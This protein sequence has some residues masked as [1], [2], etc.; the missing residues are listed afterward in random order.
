MSFIFKIDGLIKRVALIVAA[1]IICG[2]LGW[3]I[4]SHFILRAVTD[5]RLGLAPE[6]L[7]AASIRF[8]NSPRVYFRLAEAEMANAVDDQKL[9]PSALTHAERAVGLSL[10]DFKSRRLLG[11][12]QE[13]TGD[14]EKAEISLRAAVKLAPNHAETNWALANILLRRGKLDESLEPFRIA[15]RTNDDLLPLAFDLVRQSSGG[16]LNTL[17]EMAGNDPSAQLSLVQF[18]LE[19]S[20]TTEA[21]N[22]FRS[23][24]R[25]AKLTSPK[26]AAF[27]KSLMAAGQFETARTLWLDLVSSPTNS[28]S[29]SPG[30]QSG[31]QL[32]ELIWNGGFEADSVINLDHFDWTI[33]PTE[34]ARIG[35]DT[36]V[37]RNGS[38]SLRVAFA[39]RDT[40]K[41]LGEVRQLVVL[42][43]GTRYRLECYAKAADLLT[44]E[45]PRIAVIG[46]GG[47]IASSAPVAEGAT[48]WVRLVVD[49]VSPGDSSPKYV[50]LVRVPRFSYD[51]PT[52]G[53]VW[54]DDFTLT[55]Q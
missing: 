37:A 50:G 47:A 2:T 22:I 18:F 28:S 55:P 41:L 34:Y 31:D 53:V 8:P 25:Q 11:G 38:R 29:Q 26:S 42:R 35:I 7:A 30:D 33:A 4:Y 21:L 19:Q 9:I 3:L 43:P 32:R 1:L 5:P 45:G 6:A 46:Q 15:T 52:R 17:K 10:W 12:L 49:F 54:L 39:G 16:D 51:D 14:Q 36:K 44:P 40:T 48:D 13:L 23:V 27:I 24:D 20:L